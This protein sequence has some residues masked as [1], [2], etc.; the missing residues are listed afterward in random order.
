MGNKKRRLDFLFYQELGGKTTCAD[1]VF[2][3]SMLLTEH[4][5]VINIELKNNCRVEPEKV[6]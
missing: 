1:L 3:L 5:H 2:S 4:L 6:R